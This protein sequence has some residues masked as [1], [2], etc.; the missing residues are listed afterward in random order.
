MA[1]TS[2]LITADELWSMPDDGKRIELVKGELQVMTPAGFEHGWIASALCG[3][4]T[5][6]LRASQLGRVFSAD[7]GF[8]LSRNPDTVRAPDLA[9]ITT[10]RITAAGVHKKYFEGAPDLAIEVVSPD[11]RINDV[12]AKAQDYLAAG[13]ALVWVVNP[14][15][16]TVTAYAAGNDVRVFTEKDN[17]TAP[18]VLPGFSC[19]VAELFPKQPA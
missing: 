16:R 7:T 10:E 18:S 4:L 3:E 8:V 5:V 13:A 15:W 12:D 17:L 14:R 19:R 9:F 2:N 11:D 1:T 6:F